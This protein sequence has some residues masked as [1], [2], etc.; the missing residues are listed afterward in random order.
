MTRERREQ[1]KD[2]YK[3]LLN[4]SKNIGDILKE[5]NDNIGTRWSGMTVDELA[6]LCCVAS[7]LDEGLQRLNALLN[8]NRS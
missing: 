4:E 3:E 7:C 5:E 2:S 8:K 1:L 6:Q